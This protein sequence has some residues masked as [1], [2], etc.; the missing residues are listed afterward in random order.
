MHAAE[1]TIINKLVE[2]I[3]AAGFEIAVANA[4]C[5]TVKTTANVDTILFNL[6]QCDE[7]TLY[8]KN[9][10]D[11]NAWKRKRDWVQL[12]YGNE[13]EVIAEYTE[14]IEWLVAGALEL[15]EQIANQEEQS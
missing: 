3:L 6:H 14:D 2:D 1:F 4:E 5:A 15:A 10:K 9:P 13:T 12:I 8:L 7:E 11:E